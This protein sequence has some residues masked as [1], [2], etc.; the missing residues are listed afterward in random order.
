MAVKV[1]ELAHT[2]L[3]CPSQF[4]GV[5]D[6]GRIMF[7]HYR[8]GLLTVG[9]GRDFD[10]AESIGGELVRF[11]WNDDVRAPGAGGWMTV[12]DLRDVAAEWI[13]IPVCGCAGEECP[14]CE[15]GAREWP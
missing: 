11:E 8:H 13:E 2:C 3:A 1:V 12:N 6:D 14:W 9:A 5:L 4:E 15:G 10:E 7:V